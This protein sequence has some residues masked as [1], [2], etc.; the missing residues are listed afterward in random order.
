MWIQ[1]LQ[2]FN[3]SQ[4]SINALRPNRQKLSNKDSSLG[5]MDQAAVHIYEHQV[6]LQQDLLSMLNT[7]DSTMLNF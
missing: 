7:V 5:G 1:T 6:K 2:Y 3:L 4:Y